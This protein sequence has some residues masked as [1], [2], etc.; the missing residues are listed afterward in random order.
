M[1]KSKSPKII[2]YPIDNRYFIL[3]DGNL[4]CD[5]SSEEE[6]IRQVKEYRELDAKEAN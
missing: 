4:V 6:A 5:T 3:K 2:R 1:K